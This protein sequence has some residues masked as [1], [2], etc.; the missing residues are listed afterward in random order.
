MAEEL[1]RLS[2]DDIRRFNQTISEVRAIT[3]RQE[4]IAKK[5]LDMEKEIGRVRIASL[6]EYLST[7]ESALDA[8]IARKTSQLSDAF[9]IMEQKAAESFKKSADAAAEESKRIAYTGDDTGDGGSG[10]NGNNGG[11]AG[12]G[13]PPANPGPSVSTTL[14]DEQTNQLGDADSANAE[15]IAD[16][17]SAFYAKYQTLEE[18][19]NATTSRQHDAV[20]SIEQLKAARQA[21]RQKQAE[22]YRDEE[23]KLEE[24]LTALTMSRLQ[25]SSD[26]KAQARAIEIQHMQET[27]DAELRAQQLINQITAER[28]YVATPEGQALKARKTDAEENAKSIQQIEE[29]RANYIAKKELEARRKNNGILTAEEADRIR[30]RADEEY[31][32][33]QANLDKITK[34]RKE[35]EEKD[36][37]EARYKQNEQ[38]ITHAFSDPLSKDNSVWDRIKALNDIGRDEETGARSIGTAIQVAV[39]SLSTIMQQLETQIDKIAE[40]KGAVDTRLQGSS[41]KTSSGSYWD[42]IVKDMTS[43][44]AVNPYFKQEDFASK[45]KEFVDIGIAF[46]LEQ[47]AFLATVTDRIATTFNAADS[48]LLRLIRI[49]QEDST[50]GRLGMEAALNAFLNNMYENTEYLKQVADGVRSSLT[51]MQSLMEGAEA[52]EVEYQVQKWMG[53]LYSVGM[54]N[55]AVNNISRTLGQLAAGQIEGLTGD[56][57][58]NLLIM[59]ANKAGIPISNILTAGVDSKE[60]NLLMQAIVNYLAEMAESTKGNNVVQQQLA[61]VFG[62]KA[63]DLRAATNLASQESIGAIYGSSMTYDSMLGYL[64]N[65]MGSLGKRTSMGEMINNVWN[66]TLYSLA[67]GM[68]SNPISYGLLKGATLLDETTGGIN[69]PFVNVMG[70]GVDL[71]T[72]VADLMRVGALSSGILGSIGSLAQGLGNSFSG[73]KMLEQ[74]GISKGSGLAVTPRGDG[75]LSLMSGGVMTTSGSGY[76]GNASGSDIKNSTMQEA[77]DNKKQ[78]MVEA[79]EEEEQNQV[80]ILNTTVLKIYELLDDVAHGGSYLKV[81]VDNYGLTKAGNSSSSLGGV[82]ALDSLGSSSGSSAAVGLGGSAG[83]SNIADG[84]V[85]SGGIGGSIDFGGWTTTI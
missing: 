44:G 51:E 55:E 81:R 83:G 38:I 47:R 25:E 42:Q 67:G 76:V 9:L 65:M 35:Q 4:E 32:L 1:D 26:K 40:S 43:V 80:N 19:L 22:K 36:A 69:L 60:T 49:Q 11:G 8:I 45:I 41:N 77:E 10:N 53:S 12:G 30:K 16:R 59:A 18:Q 85:N 20:V 29:A 39:N 3:V 79:K 82:G 70:F 48:T 72:T 57:T 28:A 62:V 2:S 74:L 33:D 78:L 15:S 34:K 68:A 6:T 23:L 46:D 17:M 31:K 37:R 84:G 75:G 54:S 7:Y 14:T 24:T 64:Y 66:N 63:S 5:V 61:G 50:A 13:Q 27:A 52:T 73:Q 21:E 58:G 71:N 56:G